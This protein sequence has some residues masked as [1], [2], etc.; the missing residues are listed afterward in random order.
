M[1]T[2]D[3][4][5]RLSKICEAPVIELFRRNPN[6]R[7]VDLEKLICRVSHQAYSETDLQLASDLIERCIM[8]VPEDRC[9]AQEAL[10]HQFFAEL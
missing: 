2:Q 3:E 7:Q 5:T 6:C 9:L 4:M 10:Q 8:W 1:P